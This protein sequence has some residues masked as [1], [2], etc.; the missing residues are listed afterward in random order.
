MRLPINCLVHFNSTA[1]VQA[2]LA[3]LGLK[4]GTV[5]LSDVEFEDYVPVADHDELLQKLEAGGVGLLMVRETNLL[6]RLTSLL[7]GMGQ[8]EDSLRKEKNSTYI[9][10]Q[11]K[12][13]YTYLA[14]L[15]SSETGTTIE[16]FL[17][18]NKIERVK[19][20]LRQGKLNLTQIADKLHYSSVAHLSTQF[21][22]VAGLTPT[23]F[24]VGLVHKAPPEQT[25]GALADKT[26]K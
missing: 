15:F 23:H 9:S 7:L 18:N 25:G 3:R 6:D 17:I 1:E 5:N 4:H 16:H 26:E 24:L 20:L 21:K 12:H 19:M 22:K 11:L 14:N 8:G 10:Q 2:Q 13:D